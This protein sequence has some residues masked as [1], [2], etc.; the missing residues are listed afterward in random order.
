MSPASVI[1][2]VLQR[3]RQELLD[4]SARNRLISTPR[5]S[6]RSTRLEITDERSEDIYRLLVR[7]KKALSFVPNPRGDE[8]PSDGKG[9]ETG[10]ANPPVSGLSQPD[11]DVQGGEHYTDLRLQTRLG[12]E[13]LQKRLLDLSG[14]ARIFEEEQGVSILYL[15][16]GFLKWYEAPSS[17]TARYAPL[18]LIPVDL[19]RPSAAG[20]FRLK[21]REEDIATNLSLQAKLFKEFQISLPEVPDADELS[22]EAY[23]EQVRSAV[24]TQ[25]RWEVLGNDVVL[26]F[27]SFAKYLMYRD[28]DAERWPEHSPLGHNPLLSSLVQVG[29]GN[30]PPICGEDEKIDSLIQPDQMIHVTDADSSQALV[31]EEVRRGRNL[32]VQGPPGTGKSQ[33]ITN[34]I[35]AAVK[36]GKRVLFVAEKMAAL[37]VVKSRL[38]RLDLGPLCLEL[39]SHKA[40]KK[41]VISE[42]GRTL[43][44]AR[45]KVQ[46]GPSTLESLRRARDRLNEHSALMNSALDPAGVT[47][48]QVFGRLVQLAANGVQ[49][50]DFTL[51]DANRWSRQEFQERLNLLRD[52]QLHLRHVGTPARSPWRGVSL[53]Q[54]LLPSDLKRLL[55]QF[56]ELRLWLTETLETARSIASQLHISDSSPMN[57]RSV[58]ML[59][60]LVEKLLDAPPIDRAQIVHPVWDEQR[61]AITELVKNGRA[62]HD[63]Q[64]QLAGVVADI[65]WQT[66]FSSVRRELAGYGRSWFRWLRG[67]YRGAV[68]TLRGALIAELPGPLGERLAI[69]DTIIKGQKILALL[70]E[71]SPAATLAKNAFG[72]QWS[73]LSPNWLELER[74]E[75]WEKSCQNA[76]LPK[77]FR[78][79][80]ARAQEV[81][82]LREPLARL[83]AL[84]EKIERAIPA[85]WQAL[86]LDLNQAFETSDSESVSLDILID[87]LQTWEGQSETLSKWVGYWMRRDRL[88]NSGVGEFV[89]QIDAGVVSDSSVLDEFERTYYETL[90]RELFY[91]HPALSNFDG[92]SFERW[93]EEFRQLD[94]KRIGLARSEVALAHFENLPTT[95]GLGEIATIR[96]EMGKKR[97]LKPIRVL[98]K[99]AGH[100]VQSIKPVFMMSP[101]SVAQYLEPGSLE[102]DLL[103]IDEASQVSPVDAF[104]AIARAK[105]LVVVGD[106]KQ[107]PPTRFFAKMLEDEASE[108]HDDDF[109][110]GDLE[111]VLDLCQSRGMLQRML[112]WHYRSR[113]HSLIAISNREFYDNG[114][115]VAPSPTTTTDATGL[116]LRFVE[117]GVFDR[118]GTATNRIE[119][120][121]VAR[122][123]IEQA[124]NFPRQSLGIGAFSVGQR[125]AIRDELEVLL[126]QESGLDGFFSTGQAEPF[127]IKNLE[128]IQGD[129][130]DVIFISVG[131]ARDSS[132]FM[133]MNFGPLSGD[134]GE[135]RLN[136]LISRARERCD[137]FSSITADD[138]DLERGRS[139][140]TAAFKT[141]LRYAQTGILDN[142]QP[143]GDDFD[144]DFERQV[145]NS[146][147]G[148]GY[149]VHAQ[150]GSSGFIID[151]AVVDSSCPGRYL[152]GIECD[153]ATYHSSRSARDR[154][155]LRQQVLADRGWKIHRIWSTDWFHRP[156]EQLKKALAAIERAKSE[157]TPGKTAVPSAPIHTTAPV[158]AEIERDTN[159]CA[160]AHET[161]PEWVIPYVEAAIAV[162][163]ETPIP[164]IP[165]A[166]LAG[167]VRKIVD[168][169]SPVHK[170]EVQRRVGALWGIGRTGNR[171]E[172]AIDSAIKT[173]VRARMIVADG[174]F[175]A[176][177]DQKIIHIRT[178]DSERLGPLRKPEMIAPGE[179]RTAVQRLVTEHVGARRDEVVTTV[180]RFL[181]FRS[182]SPQL[183]E[184]IERQIDHLIHTGLI[185]GR[186]EKLFVSE[187]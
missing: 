37:Q 30:E 96:H 122:A 176:I 139:R 173:A 52:F 123:A 103:I 6:S 182:T 95:S 174:D 145:A 65:A 97:N 25:Q 13:R 154:D 51:K 70:G 134:G 28:L 155:R 8:L 129:E 185:S 49:P 130:R 41:A 141:F 40:N 9:D 67:S 91:N 80:V 62:L 58:R 127:F 14:D 107:L 64:S 12:S 88:R 79:I 32:V 71:N 85:V 146:I 156:Q 53:D 43:G 26:W 110:A 3:S 22:P 45:P 162:P 36:E 16:L 83:N 137:V 73:A 84:R 128:N 165:V 126:R 47:P 98:L 78:K 23:F 38:D 72:S 87:R 135:R 20:R 159:G 170:E 120:R 161:T 4:L 77:A 31:I 33:T 138:I 104:G 187:L 1:E 106:N 105:Q 100:A 60:R 113:H 148:M 178:R 35:G 102:F 27:F 142:Q 7:E 90:V 150:V 2:R 68:A 136:V 15:A 157:L 5:G 59:G 177:P 111:S 133:A 44:L 63:C 124:R 48:F 121:A 152:L 151:L 42:I 149:T 147:T 10:E 86:K 56:C 186:D 69:V 34:M 74:I 76:K 118:G 180:A 101:I 131:Y 158:A 18:L 183:R 11:D 61:Q 75:Q 168:V 144:S 19:E 57:I 109:A 54:P 99:E 125:D 164:E 169:E 94:L 184:I 108:G 167:V 24:G 181:G 117:G 93:I 172:Q 66:E 115:F 89:D 119:A 21:F 50:A 81:E 39:H 46:G 153:G 112:R 55:S 160:P 29:F 92:E 82:S 140:G 171:I 132:G 114:L 179:I 175:L 17:D 163:R 116:R 166:D 143:T